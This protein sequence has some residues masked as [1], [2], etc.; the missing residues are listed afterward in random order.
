MLMAA[1]ALPSAAQQSG[2]TSTR[3]PHGNLAIPC[4]NC[5]TAAAWKP[6]RAIPEFDHNKTR[7]PLRGMHEN[8]AC[9]QCHTKPVFTNVGSKCAD[10]HADI[11]RRQMGANCE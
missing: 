8:V 11:H 5:H 2:Y 7:Y 3:S 4:Q 9:V 1:A 6:I 10:C